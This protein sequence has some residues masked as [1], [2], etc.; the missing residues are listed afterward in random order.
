MPKVKLNQIRPFLNLTT[1]SPDALVARAN[2]VKTGITNNPAYPNPPVDPATLK[3]AIDSYLVASADGLDSKKA[4]AERDKQ[5]IV[6]IRLLRQ[7]GHY[8]EAN[9]NDDMPTFLS[10]GFEPV[11]PRTPPQPLP[12]ANI[13]GVDQGTTGQLLV[14]IKPLPKARHYEL[15]Y[16]P[17]VAD[18]T[19]AASTTITLPSAKAAAPINGLTPGATYTF[20]VRAYSKLGFTGWSDSVSRMCI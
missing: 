19:P 15:K 1:L 20:Q 8:V 14:S 18:G 3:A 11:S 16:S 6:L 4:R 10:S 5:H 17:V 2:A 9:S 12:P 7:I 13:L